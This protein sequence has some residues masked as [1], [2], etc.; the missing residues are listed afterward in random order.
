M[1]N[2]RLREWGERTGG[3][4][5]PHQA[6]RSRLPLCALSPHISISLWFCQNQHGLLKDLRE[7]CYNVKELIL[8]LSCDLSSCHLLC[9]WFSSLLWWSL[10]YLLYPKFWPSCVFFWSLFFFSLWFFQKNLRHFSALLL[11]FAKQ[12]LYVYKFTNT[13]TFC[14]YKYI[15]YISVCYT[16]NYILRLFRF[17]K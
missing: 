3:V 1:L 6:F 8:Q 5:D 9:H 13:H 17:K 12:D 11:E 15:L 14:T 4:T 10:F 7:E 2:T 16:Y